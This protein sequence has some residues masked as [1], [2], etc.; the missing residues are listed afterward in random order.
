MQVC[1]YKYHDKWFP[2]VPRKQELTAFYRGQGL[3][4]KMCSRKHTSRLSKAKRRGKATKVKRRRK[5]GI[6]TDKPLR[7][8]KRGRSKKFEA[9]VAFAVNCNV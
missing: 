7:R 8:S 6:D 4:C 2:D 3:T 5:R 9:L 1:S